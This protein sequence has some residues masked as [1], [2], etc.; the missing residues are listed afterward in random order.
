MNPK[1][2]ETLEGWFRHQCWGAGGGGG[3]GVP[4]TRKFHRYIC[5]CIYLCIC[6][7]GSVSGRDNETAAR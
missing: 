4:A 6:F 2:V 7:G 5:L 3:G 1:E